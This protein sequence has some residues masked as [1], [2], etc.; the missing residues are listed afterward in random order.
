MPNNCNIE[1]KTFKESEVNFDIPELARLK[2]F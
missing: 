1:I 2:K